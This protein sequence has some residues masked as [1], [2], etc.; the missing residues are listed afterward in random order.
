MIL[1]NRIS[2]SDRSESAWKNA[3]LEKARHGE[4]AYHLL[5]QQQNDVIPKLRSEGA[6]ERDLTMLVEQHESGRDDVRARIRGHEAE[7]ILSASVMA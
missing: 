2:R 1:A 7:I 3:P 5:R 4:R 6:Q